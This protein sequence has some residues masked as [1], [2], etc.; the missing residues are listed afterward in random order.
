M[1]NLPLFF[2]S[3]VYSPAS[4]CATPKQ[5]I[6]SLPSIPS[7]RRGLHGSVGHPLP[8]PRHNIS[9]YEHRYNPPL[10]TS[11]PVRTAA[12][13]QRRRCLNLDTGHIADDIANLGLNPL[14]DTKERFRAR[15]HGQTNTTDREKGDLLLLAENLLESLMYLS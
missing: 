11:I 9:P 12:H 3:P 2:G 8:L 7:E 4:D 13:P 10:P 5:P 1:A 15:P 6:V 14:R